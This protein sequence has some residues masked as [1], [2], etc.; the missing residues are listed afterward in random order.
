MGEASTMHVCSGSIRRRARVLVI[1]G[2]ALILSGLCTCADAQA[3]PPAIGSARSRQRITVMTYNIHAGLGVDFVYSLDRIAD[4]I[5]AERVDLI[6][7]CEVEQKTQKVNF[8][9]QA[10]LIADRL[11]FYHAYGPIFARPTGFFCNA[12]VSRY[13]ILSH[14][15]HQ[16][17]NPNRTQARAALEAQVDVDG[18]IVTVFVTHLEV[19][20]S[21]SRVAQAEAL[22]DIASSTPTPRIIMGDF[23]ATP[24][25]ALETALM[26]REHNDTYALHRVLV[27]SRWLVA[28][29]PF[30][31]EYLKGG[32]TI[33]VFDPS[34]RIDYI[35]ASNDIGVAGEIGI[36]RVPR[37]LAS[38]HLP[39]V[40]TLELPRKQE[41]QA[42]LAATTVDATAETL[43]SRVLGPIRPLP[44]S[45]DGCGPLVAVMRSEDVKAWYEDMG[46]Y[47][48]DD[49]DMIEEMVD[50]IGLGGL[51]CAL[52]PAD[53]LQ[54]L[55]ATV[56]RRPTLLVL[57]NAR[58]MSERQMRAV[59]DFVAVG[60]R[61]LATYQTSLK[62]EA[63]AVAGEYGFG[64]ADLFGA[65]LAGWTGVSP[66][67]D[68]IAPIG[69]GEVDAA[70]GSDAVIRAIWEGVGAPVRLRVPE[71]MVTKPWPGSV[72][73]GQ[74]SDRTGAP[75]RALPLNAA[76]VLNGPVMY[77]GADLL[78]WDALQEEPARAL[79]A[80]M[81]RF[82]LGVDH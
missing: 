46:W 66:M 47:Y 57:S 82:M 25:H 65:E 28:L 7:L 76:I 34:A 10:K 1:A 5:R 72:V 36:A 80:N 81:V 37:S 18:T 77:V 38:D 11:G 39:Y 22:A 6:G 2:I 26:L 3:T 74:W 35:F 69:K 16:L 31:R 75:S 54:S 64:L 59:R 8:D 71:G 40:V 21:G 48:E 19:A 61:V 33:G 30:E 15:V 45:P 23:N 58:R 67:H 44:D 52:V 32:Y 53:E 24:T 51:E 63:E 50:G 4:L 41:G 29:G 70:N 55:V 68:A 49:L 17:P 62:T 13:P 42:R 60:G 14:R 43:G 20:D 56:S 27:D 12:L 79:A 9:D 78:S 73:L